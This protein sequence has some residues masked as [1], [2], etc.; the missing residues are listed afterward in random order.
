MTVRNLICFFLVVICCLPYFEAAGQETILEVQ[1]ETRLE[2]ILT[3]N[4][5]PNARV[6]F[7]IQEINENL[8]QITKMPDDVHFSVESTG[9]WTLSIAA[10]DSYFTGT[11]DS[12]QKIPVDFIGFTVQNLGTNWDN[13]LFSNIA[14]VSKDT[15]LSLSEERIT[16]LTNGRVG[17][18]GGTDKNSFLLRWKF[19]LEDEPAKITRFTGMRLKD[20]YY[21]G[22]FYIILTEAQEPPKSD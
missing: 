17:N 20:D 19:V 18:I 6:E 8:Y 15:T 21:T 11:N 2:S 14:N 12:T 9:N 5:D 13:G 10:A 16:I 22:N 1:F 7:G 4:I 3:L